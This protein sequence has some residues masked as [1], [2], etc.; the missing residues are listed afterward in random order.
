M[1]VIGSILSNDFPA[2][3]FSAKIKLSLIL[4]ENSAAGKYLPTGNTSNDDSM[5]FMK[6]KIMIHEVRYLTET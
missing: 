1:P 6:P 2:T 4:A 3:P 5:M